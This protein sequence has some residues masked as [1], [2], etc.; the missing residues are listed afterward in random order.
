MKA[1]AEILKAESRNQFNHGWTRMDTDNKK[2]K[3]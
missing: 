2:L 3:S 1:K